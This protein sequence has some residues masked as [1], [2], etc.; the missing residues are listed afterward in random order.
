MYLSKKSQILIV[1]DYPTNIKVLSD[2][3]I[4][5]GF[6]V[7]I[8]RD[9]MNALQKLQ[10]ILPD[11]ILLD[12]LMPGIDGFE[13][14]Q[15]LKEQES[16]R[17]IPVI[18][19]TALSDPVDKIKGLSL[20]AV[21]YITKPFQQEEVLARVNTHLRIRHLTK[22]LEE[23]NAQLRDEAR[24]RQLAEASLRLSEEK[25][26]KA[27]RSNPGPMMILTLE[28]GRFLEVNQNFCKILEYP[29]E[30]LLGKTIKELNIFCD[31]TECDRF[32][33]VLQQDNVVSRQEWL[34][35]TFLGET[36]TLLVSAEIIHVRE[37]TCILA[38]MFDITACKKAAAELQ[39]AKAAA[40][41]ANQAKSLFLASISHE[42]RMPLT[43]I[44]GY[45]KLMDR[46]ESLNPQQREYLSVIN[47]SG[48]HLFV[49]IND[50]LE[51]TR[52][53]SGLLTLNLEDI[54]LEV[55]LKTIYEM[56]RPKAEEKQLQFTFEFDPEPCLYIQSDQT[57]L[58]QVLINL[59][60]NAI[61]FTSQGTV[62]LRVSVASHL[63]EKTSLDG[64]ASHPE[65]SSDHATPSSPIHL[66]FEVADT[67]PGITPD[68][69]EVLFDPFVQTEAGRRSQE[70]TGLG[71]PITQRF[72]QFMGGNITVQSTVGVGSVFTVKIPVALAYPLEDDQTVQPK[73]R[74]IGLAPGQPN[75]RILVVDDQTLNR[76]LLVKLF[77][78]IGFEVQEAAQGEEAIAIYQSWQPQLIWM[79][80][81]MPGMD[82][83]EATRRIRQL[84]VNH[85]AVNLSGYRS[86]VTAAPQPIVAPKI[87]ALT[88]NAFEADRSAALAAGYDDFV[89]KPIQEASLLEKMSEHLGVR[90]LYQGSESLPSYTP[91]GSQKANPIASLSSSVQIDSNL[92]RL[93]KDVARGDLMI[94]ADYIADNLE[95][96]GELVQQLRAA[97]DAQDAVALGLAAHSL[98]ATGMT[99]EANNLV[100]L[101]LTVEQNAN[102]GIATVRPE[103]L[104]QLEAELKQLIATLQFQQTRLRQM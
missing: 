27:F 71:L 92:Q 64:D 97:V 35:S 50:V 15:R 72:V 66:L 60:G 49:V 102:A 61:K 65:P 47:R 4:E 89:C 93:L 7:L 73:G 53:E 21:D 17:D 24:S 48:E 100:E 74:V 51:M 90:Y 14:C 69:L 84:Q 95:E 55:F 82:G 99:F 79:D 37:L 6:E 45:T 38:M 39:Q 98:R 59:L 78:T 16:T 36:K 103:Q 10:R 9:G 42:L 43:V 31:P 54:N 5:Y 20:G 62:S 63:G 32:L 46:D 40:E 41:G 23:Q 18:F 101:C 1:D 19:M 22:Q 3:L 76:K 86:G 83:Y 88:A 77:T 58:R 96:L 28:E 68:E 91:L 33:A 75:Y 87:I 85:E 25:F 12:V 52:I 2:L 44:L 104:L 30:A 29:P 70:G 11:I 13:T 67:G 34:F 81:R 57:K 80:V 26:V 56:L 94:L 8:A